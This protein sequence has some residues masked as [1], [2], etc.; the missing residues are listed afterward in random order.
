MSG[1]WEL[2][3]P[4][5]AMQAVLV[6]EV[7]HFSAL[8]LSICKTDYQQSLSCLCVLHS[9][10]QVVFRYCTV[11][12][13]QPSVKWLCEASCRGVLGW[14]ISTKLSFGL[15]CC[16]SLDLYSKPAGFA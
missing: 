3:S 1:V 6:D 9:E 2:H 14:Q 4:A 13:F 7:P 5:L 11:Q 10:D 12:V 8:S 16:F 15:I